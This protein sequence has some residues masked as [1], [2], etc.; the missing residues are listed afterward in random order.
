MNKEEWMN[1]LLGDEL[2][3]HMQYVIAAQFVKGKEGD[4][5]F[6]EFEQHAK[7]EQEHF[8][9]L[10]NYMVSEKMN[11]NSDLQ[12]LITQSKSGY[13]KMTETD[14]KDLLEFHLKAEEDAI[15]AYKEFFEELDKEEKPDVKLLEIIRDII[16]DE[17]EH[18]ED[19]EKILKIVKKPQDEYFDY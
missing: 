17:E 7:E 8:T 13:T 2:I 3:A 15:K 12:T 1:K 4:R 16:K 9:N 6:E 5:C 19:L 14:K 10:L 11:V 18:K